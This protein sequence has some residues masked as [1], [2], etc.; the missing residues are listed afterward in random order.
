MVVLVAVSVLLLLQKKWLEAALLGLSGLA[1]Y[2]IPVITY[3]L[4][5]SRDS[6]DWWLG[7]SYTRITASFTIVAFFSL[8]ALVLWNAPAAKRAL[9]PVIKVRQPKSKKRR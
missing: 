8:A 1:L 3:A 5:N 6:I 4:G 7:T 2:V 9:A